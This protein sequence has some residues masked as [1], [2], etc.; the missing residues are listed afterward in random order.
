MRTL[1]ARYS[2]A[3]DSNWVRFNNTIAG[4]AANWHLARHRTHLPE[5][6]SMEYVE[7]TETDR[8][9]GWSYGMQFGRAS[10]G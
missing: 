2:A 8:A 6:G 1:E 3:C 5:D 4:A 10:L 7:K 9:A